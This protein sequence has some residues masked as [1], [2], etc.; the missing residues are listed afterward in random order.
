MAHMPMSLR[1]VRLTPDQLQIASQAA[2]V[3]GESYSLVRAF[4]NAFMLQ[5]Y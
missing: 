3:A 2:R 4:G 1:F 5:K